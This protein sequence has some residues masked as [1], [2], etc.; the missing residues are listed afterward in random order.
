MS[1][2]EELDLDG[3]DAP[4][5]GS[6][7]KKKGGVGSIL[8][9][10]LK[11][12]A[13][14]LGA[15]IFIVTVSVVTFSIMNKGGKQQTAVVDPTSPYQGKRP[16]YTY[17]TGIGS[18]STKT[19]DVVGYSVTV[20]MILGYDPE[21]TAAAV[22]LAGR[23][24]ELRDFVRRYF[25]GKYAADLAPEREE[26]LKQEIREILNTRFLDTTRVRIVLF[27]KLDVMEAF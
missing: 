18:V 10:I 20:D 27:N 23:Q 17:Y 2:S 21:E 12:A 7:A 13:I 6:S 15:L 26:Q 19:K 1:D 8:P 24:Y 16:I 14:G 5:A 3:G 25:T 9:T 11:F 22:E 4:E